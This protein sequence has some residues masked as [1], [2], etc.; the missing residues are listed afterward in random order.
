[1]KG[2]QSIELPSSL[3]IDMHLCCT[4][5]LVLVSSSVLRL[6]FTFVMRLTF[7]KFS[8]N[9]LVHWH[10][11]MISCKTIRKQ[12][13]RNTRKSAVPIILKLWQVQ[14]GQQREQTTYADIPTMFLT[15]MGWMN[16]CFSKL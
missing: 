14:R 9:I 12:L 5:L 11:I 7:T 15:L 8:H 3:L 4:K 1:M 6:L 10:V 16:D 13:A 2:L